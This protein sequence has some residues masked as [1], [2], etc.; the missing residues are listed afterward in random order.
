MFNMHWNVLVSMGK[1][2][3][4]YISDDELNDEIEEAIEGDKYHNQAH[5]FTN[6]AKNLLEDDE[7]EKLV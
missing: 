2:W 3:S 5:F 1:T 7:P 4:V 6:A